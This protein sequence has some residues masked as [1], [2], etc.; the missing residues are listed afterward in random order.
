M[1]GLEK[2]CYYQASLGDLYLRKGN[3]PEAKKYFEKALS[4]VTSNA[5]VEL[6]TRKINTC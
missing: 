1:S 2:N 4:L 6:I 5:E 3:K